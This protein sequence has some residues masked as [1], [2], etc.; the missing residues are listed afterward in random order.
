MNF[1]SSKNLQERIT[2]YERISSKYPNQIPV[3]CERSKS[4][5][6]DIPVINKSKFLVPKDLTCGQFIQV[7]RS[8]VKIP[9]EKAIFLFVGS[10]IPSGNQLMSDIYGNYKDADGFLYITYTGEN[11]FGL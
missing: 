1:K 4:S 8:R 3:I 5:R 2:E 6:N 10:N 9:P 7:I 11:T